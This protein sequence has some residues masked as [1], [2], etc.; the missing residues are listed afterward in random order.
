MAFFK[1]EG[2]DTIGFEESVWKR[3]GHPAG[4]GKFAEGIYVSAHVHD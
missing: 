3:V 4:G 2:F 1:S